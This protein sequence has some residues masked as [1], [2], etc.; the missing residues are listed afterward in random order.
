MPDPMAG[1]V[2]LP[3]VQLLNKLEIVTIVVRKR[4]QSRFQEMFQK[5][6][7]WNMFHLSSKGV[8]S[9]GA[10]LDNNGNNSGNSKSTSNTNNTNKL[11]LI[12]QMILIVVGRTLIM[13]TI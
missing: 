12:V 1:A 9:K 3:T 10:T 4:P 2:F 7:F 13:P 11:V 8:S 5:L 6:F